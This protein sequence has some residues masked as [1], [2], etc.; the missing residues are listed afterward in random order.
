MVNNTTANAFVAATGFETSGATV[1]SVTV[2]TNTAIYSVNLTFSGES[3]PPTAIMVMA[4]DPT[5][6]KYEMHPYRVDAADFNINTVS[7]D[8]TESNGQ[9]T[10]DIFGGF[11]TT[12]LNIDV[13]QSY[14]KYGNAVTFPPPSRL[15]HA[16]LVF[17]F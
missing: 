5:T 10:P 1:D 11:G 2:N 16:Y 8:F 4:W 14:I 7:T 12:S 17:I 9:W 13:R 6:Y 3:N 15:S